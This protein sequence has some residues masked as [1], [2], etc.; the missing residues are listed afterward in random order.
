MHSLRWPTA[1]LLMMTF[2]FL[3]GTLGYFV[4]RSLVLRPPPIIV[5]SPIIDAG[6]IDQGQTITRSFTIQNKSNY[7]VDIVGVK[8]SCACTGL[9]VSTKN[10][11]PH[12]KATVTVNINTVGKLGPITVYGGVVWQIRRTRII[13]NSN[14][15]I[16]AEITQV[17][18]IRPSE[19]HIR[20][21]SI[22]EKTIEL[23]F[24]IEHGDSD[25]RWNNVHVQ[26]TGFQFET[27]ELPSG[28]FAI[29]GKFDPSTL[30]IGVYKDSIQLD[31][32]DAG[33]K[34]MK[35]YLIPFEGDVH[36][37][38]TVT[39]AYAYL[40]VLGKNIKRDGK[41]TLRSPEG[42]RIDS[43]ESSD[44]EFFSAKTEI[45]YGDK[46]VLDYHISSGDKVGSRSG[47]LSIWVHINGQKKKI[48]FPFIAY[49][50]A[51]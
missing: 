46:L 20:N 27:T 18:R 43:L 34:E 44:P 28:G 36:A 42:L 45:N 22:E 39:P 38:L 41:I 5:E 4:K 35:R 48:L 14:L 9:L 47:M 11:E 21:L 49:V 23:Q 3:A 7:I 2:I 33:N 40:S 25:I 19:I 31:L 32:L 10:L 12:A 8:R 15:L 13:G 50:G 37:N 26:A 30:P 1:L 6:K 24:S 16:K 17:A 51:S 29:K